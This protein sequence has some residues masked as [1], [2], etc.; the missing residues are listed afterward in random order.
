MTEDR[1]T[2]IGLSPSLPISLS[3]DSQTVI[4]TIGRN[5]ETAIRNKNLVK[6]LTVKIIET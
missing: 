1:K 2:Q 3:N 5:L 6:P 4:S